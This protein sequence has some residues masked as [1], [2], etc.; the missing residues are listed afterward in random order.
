MCVCVCVRVRAS[1]HTGTL[2]VTGMCLIKEL[3]HIALFC[4]ET[5]PE[6]DPERDH[7]NF[8]YNYYEHML[9]RQ[10]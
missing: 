5:R 7:N 10:L 8:D 4:L 6:S 1:D 3:L 9:S 2:L